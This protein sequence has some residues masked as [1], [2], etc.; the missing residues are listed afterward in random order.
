M[1]VRIEKGLIH[2]AGR[3]PA[4]D[5]E[6]LLRALEEH[7][8]AV[9]DITGLHRLHMAVMQVLLALRPSIRGPAAMGP[10]SRQIFLRLISDN[11]RAEKN[12]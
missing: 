9:V 2:L 7:P 3:C 10:F 4:E 5:A 12:S 1:S 8:Q 6:D 11:D